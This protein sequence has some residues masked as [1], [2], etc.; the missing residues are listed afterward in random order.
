MREHAFAVEDLHAHP[1]SVLAAAQDV[2]DLE[3]LPLR[4]DPIRAVHVEAEEVLDPV[5][6]VGTRTARSDL[7][8]PRLDRRRWSVDP[9][10]SRRHDVGGVEQ[11][12]ARK[13]P[14]S[15]LG[16]RPQVNTH[17]RAYLR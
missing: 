6:G 9:D 2:T 11:V 3:V 14:R 10:R 17:S 4:V 12:V 1:G 13:G 8:Q 7:N 16:C 15:L 5:I